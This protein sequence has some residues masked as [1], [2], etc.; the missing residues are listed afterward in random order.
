[1]EWNKDLYETSGD[2]GDY[3]EV[4]PYYT[5]M[6]RAFDPF[7]L[8]GVNTPVLDDCD[9]AVRLVFR[10]KYLK[11]IQ[12]H[13]LKMRKRR[14]DDPQSVVECIKRSLLK[15]ICKRMLSKEYKTNFPDTVP[16]IVIHRWVIGT[17]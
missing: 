15:Y 12:R 14:T 7:D 11:Y 4:E 10:M 5:I 16:A 8:K 9:R 2:S 1:M 17:T 6:R 3:G 13:K